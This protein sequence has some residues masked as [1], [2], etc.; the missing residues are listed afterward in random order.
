[1]R[2]VLF[3]SRW[4]RQRIASTLARLFFLL[5]GGFVPLVTGT[6]AGAIVS[7]HPDDIAASQAGE[8]NPSN[9]IM[10]RQDRTF[11]D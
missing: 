9:I 7:S 10:S 8:E 1:M 11:S 5:A 3:F 6:P 2:Y 4:S